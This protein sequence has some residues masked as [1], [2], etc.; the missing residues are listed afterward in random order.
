[1][2]GRGPGCQPRWPSSDEHLGQGRIVSKT[3]DESSCCRGKGAMLRDGLLLAGLSGCCQH[4]P[5][6]GLRAR[7]LNCPAKP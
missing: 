1:M 3:W 2:G 6:Q 7:W 5:A 4:Q